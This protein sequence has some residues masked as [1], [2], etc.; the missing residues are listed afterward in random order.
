[1]PK[2]LGHGELGGGLRYLVERWVDGD[3]LTTRLRMA[4]H[5]P[6][7]IEG[8]SRVHLGY[9][10][11]TRRVSE[12]WHRG[13]RE[14][15]QDVRDAELVPAEQGA[16]VAELIAAD[17]RLRLSWS[18]G[19]LVASNVLGTDDGV[20][21]ID[22]EHAMERPVMH[23]AAK[24]HLFA[25]EKDPLLDLLLEEWGQPEASGG[26]SAAEELVI[27]HARFL[28]RAPVRMAELAG[29]KREGVYARQVA[30]QADLLSDAL[31]RAV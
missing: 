8:L 18:H 2:L 16:R 24:L 31:E 12:I 21:I 9:G 25:A 17:K 14:Q 6:Q 29:H 26:Y 11:H 27:V 19:D 28:S 13:F 1:M 5:L 22:W 3:P 23:D 20:V 10:V 4:A 7:I 30:R 15:W